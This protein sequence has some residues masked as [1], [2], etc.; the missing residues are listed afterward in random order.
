MKKKLAIGI[1]TLPLLLAGCGG[2]SSSSGTGTLNLSLTDAPIDE[3]QAVWV[4][5]TGVSIKKQNDD[6]EAA[7]EWID[8]TFDQPKSINLLTLQGAQN[9]EL[10]TGQTLEAGTYSEIRLHV[11]AVQDGVEDSYITL[12]DGNHELDIPSGS[13]TGLKVKGD[14]VV[15]ADQAVGFTVDFDVRKS[16]V[17]LGT[18]EYKL[19]PVLHLTQDTLTGHIAGTVETQLLTSL[20]DNWT[21]SDEDPNTYNAVYIY[22]GADATPVDISGGATDPVSTALVNYNADTTSYEFEAG[23][24]T[25]G[26]YT[27]SF[28]CHADA[29]DIGTSND[30]FFIGTQNVTVTAGETATANIVAP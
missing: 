4:E 11:N 22:S 14:I 17:V 3:A 8:I 30:L 9:I 5:F 28:T 1:V 20:T 12:D 21:C 29:E 27:V 2:S 23:Y 10:L 16:I 26:T 6:P 19:K 15:E 7:E 24:L 25:A 13:Q 18:G